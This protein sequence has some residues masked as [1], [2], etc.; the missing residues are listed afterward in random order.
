M[1]Y[2]DRCNQVERNE[3]SCKCCNTDSCVVRDEDIVIMVVPLK[4]MLFGTKSEKLLKCLLYIGTLFII[5][6]V[7]GNH[8]ILRFWIWD[9]RI[10]LP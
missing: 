8:E 10:Y 7:S 3:Q 1:C 2:N 9:C 4:A 5:C 6:P